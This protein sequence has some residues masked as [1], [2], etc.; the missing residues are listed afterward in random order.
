M[1][2]PIV[3]VS[4]DGHLDDW[5]RQVVEL[6]RVDGAVNVDVPR[7]D[8]VAAAAELGLTLVPLARIDRAGPVMW[9][10]H[11]A[12][13]GPHNQREE[14]YVIAC[15]EG[16]LWQ[17]VAA[18]DLTDE[19]AAELD[20]S[21]M[22]VRRPRSGD[23]V[24]W[25]QVQGGTLLDRTVL[26]L[27]E[28]VTRDGPW[29]CPTIVWVTDPDD[30]ED[31]LYFWNLR[32]LRPLLPTTQPMLL[33]PVDEV[34]HWLEFDR[35][36]ARLLV[37][38][39]EFSPDV[40]LR[41]LGVEESALHH[42]AGVLGL[43]RSNDKV[44]SGHQFPPPPLREAPFTYRLDVDI[45]RWFV[46]NREYGIPTDVDVHLFK[47]G[48]RVRFSSPVPFTGAGYALVRLAGTPFAGLPQRPSVAALVVTN[49]DW[50]G[51]SIQ[52]RANASREFQFEVHVP[53]LEEA[54]H[55]L[56]REVTAGYQ[57]SDKGRLGT[58]MQANA[59]VSALLE[60]GVY[61]ALVELTTP[62]SKELLRELQ[63][64]QA[65]G[66]GE[67]ELAE[68]AIRWGG[69]TERRYR[70]AE[71]L[72]RVGKMEA[73]AVLERLCGL[74]WAE[75]GLEIHCQRCGIRSFVPLSEA[76]PRGQP[77]CRGCGAAQGYTARASALSILYRLDTFVDRASDQGVLSHL[78][79][80][81]AL[82]RRHT[83]SWVIPGV[84]V[85]LGDD[86]TKEADIFGVY[87]AHVIA[88]E[89]KTTASQFTVEQMTRD[90][91][92][93]GRLRADTHLLAAVDDI[94]DETSATARDLCERAGLDLL[95]LGRDDLRPPSDQ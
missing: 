49:A 24:A 15:A 68:L 1:T 95:I 51:G 78:L 44:R 2:E 18:G 59:D 41:S 48:S 4:A 19:H 57:L 86:R 31:C 28:D 55:A 21:V 88:G 32:A 81:A 20:A 75:R 71:N 60:P 80:V 3:P 6:A 40:V 22:A 38:P 70:G 39:S 25:A 62:R 45:R 30:L 83:R 82:A 34:Q 72:N 14:A 23:E 58:A 37:R 9:T 26:H 67:K 54:V 13:V 89:V 76:S 94:P 47:D 73:P 33:L 43:Q 35:Q 63:R 27:A 16:P 12:W 79:V 69:R 8:A 92:L 93:S 61:E 29:P 65:Q 17:A 52:I 64:F 11:P 53:S 85:S 46:F 42:L 36:F 90:V 56:L 5:W 74:G 84:E 77:I 66:A 7:D 50:R 10:C 87:D 91:A